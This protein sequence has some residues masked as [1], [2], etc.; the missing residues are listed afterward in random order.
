MG[1]GNHAVA[2][3]EMEKRYQALDIALKV[4]GEG[5]DELQSQFSPELN[6][7]AGE[8]IYYI[9][10][11]KYS[12]LLID[13]NYEIRLYSPEDSLSHEL[14]Y[15]STG[16]VD[17]VYL[18][19]RLALLELLESG[20]DKAPLILDDTF[21]QFDDERLERV[22]ETLLRLSRDRQIIL[23]TCRG[24][25]AGAA[26]EKGRGNVLEIQAHKGLTIP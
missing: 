12:Q 5:L 1:N 10:N 7:L 26:G 2:D 25:E 21:A 6:K 20:P 18:A 16:T 15:F 8:N 3:R 4:I 17:Q 19:V 13:K 11:G 9:T 14:S 24:R 23:M 22:L